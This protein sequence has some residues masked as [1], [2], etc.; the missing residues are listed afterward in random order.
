MSRPICTDGRMPAAPQLRI[1]VVGLHPR[2][3]SCVG[4]M[5]GDAKR[6]AAIER[7]RA[8]AAYGEGRC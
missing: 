8:L 2:S 6:K 3:C 1:A 5:A 4:C 7:E